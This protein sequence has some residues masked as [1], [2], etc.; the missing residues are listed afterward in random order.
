VQPFSRTW[1]QDTRVERWGVQVRWW[2][3]GRELFYVDP[4]NRLTVV[5]IAART[6]GQLA[7]GEPATLFATRLFGG[8]GVARQQY[9]VTAD[10]QRFLLVTVDEETTPTPITFVLNWKPR[11]N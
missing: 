11:P 7:I 3:D 4:G 5:S 1:P 10:G 8:A 9:A 6:G 2:R